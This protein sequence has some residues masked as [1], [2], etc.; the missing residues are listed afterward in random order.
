VAKQNPKPAKLEQLPEFLRL[1][2]KPGD[3]PE[4]LAE[5]AARR[6]VIATQQ[7]Q[8]R[9]EARQR[10]R[11]GPEARKVQLGLAHEV[12]ARADVEMLTSEVQ[13]AKG[14]EK[15]EKSV[16]LDI[17]KARLADALAE[18]GRYDEAAAAA[19]SAEQQAEYAGLWEAVWRDDEATCPCEPFVEGEMSLT[20]DHVA[21]EVISQKHGNRLM[22]A[23]RCNACGFLNVRPLTHELQRLERARAQ[24]ATLLLGHD[25]KHLKH[26]ATDIL[27]SLHDSKVLRT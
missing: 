17:A 1:T 20:H 19:P 23:I 12:S 15:K 13:S 27:A 22:P 7:E 10:G 21:L 18:Q 3:T 26:N 9:T 16:R 8:L 11:V 6:A 2:P 5:M 4:K 14:K 24:A 25:A